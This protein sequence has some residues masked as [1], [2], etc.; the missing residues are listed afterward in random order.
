MGVLLSWPPRRANIQRH[1]DETK[2]VPHPPAMQ[3]ELQ[4][5]VVPDLLANAR[6][7]LKRE[8]AAGARL[9][10]GPVLLPRYE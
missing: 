10:S 6:V 5:Q 3:L 4:R 2:K 7:D 8:N 9:A 1:P